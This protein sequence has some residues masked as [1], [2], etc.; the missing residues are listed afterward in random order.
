MTALRTFQQRVQRG[1]AYL[2]AIKPGWAHKIDVEELDITCACQCVLGQLY[3]NFWTDPE[4]DELLTQSGSF[5]QSITL[6]FNYDE[7]SDDYQQI[8][9]ILERLWRHQIKKR[10][11]A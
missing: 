10:R 8:P 11:A 5:K 1:A 9:A 3:G 7:D 6:G 2:D 4:S